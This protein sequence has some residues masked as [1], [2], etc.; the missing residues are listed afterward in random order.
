MRIQVLSD[1][2]LEHSDYSAT[3]ASD[4]D[5]VVLAGD[6]SVG[7]AGVIWAKEQFPGLPVLYVPGNHEYYT[8][9][10]G[11]LNAALAEEAAGSNVHVLMN[12]KFELGGYVNRPGNRGGR[13]I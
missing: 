4:T 8:H 7:T 10:I 13:L 12:T 11:E 2:H 3:L 5:L 9:D 1:L 6:I